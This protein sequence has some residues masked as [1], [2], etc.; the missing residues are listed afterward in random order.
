MKSKALS[1][2]NKSYAQR[3]HFKKRLQERYGLAINADSYKAILEAIDTGNRVAVV[4]NGH[5]LNLVASYRA[6][7]SKRVA[8]WALIL[9]G[10]SEP[11]PVAYDTIRKELITTHPD[12]LKSDKNSLD[13]HIDM[14]Y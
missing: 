6:S 8:V 3:D 5:T 13:S 4:L 9:G 7:Q 11:I 12:L 1:S 2:K 14:L 10:I